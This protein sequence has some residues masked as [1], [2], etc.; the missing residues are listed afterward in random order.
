L[1]R[2]AAKNFNDVV[3][4]SSKN[5]YTEL[6][7]ILAAQEG[8]TSL[9]QRKSF[10]KRAFNTSSHYDTAIFNYFNQEEPIE[11]F[12]RSKK[13]KYCVTARIHTKKVFSSVTWM[14]CLT[15]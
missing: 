2:A 12:N 5:D 3:I 4:I 14:R 11:V 15:N 8:A 7:E 9:E 13:R 10:A 1:I 6:E